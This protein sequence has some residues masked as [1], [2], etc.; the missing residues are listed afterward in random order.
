MPLPLSEVLDLEQVED[1]VFHGHSDPVRPMRVFGGQVASQALVAAGRTVPPGRPVHSLHA[2]FLRPGDP[3]VPLTYEVDPIRDGRTFST[4]RVT[5]HQGDE[6]IFHLSASFQVPEDGIEHQVH[7]VSPV[8]PDDLPSTE[9]LLAHSPAGKAWWD[10]VKGFFPLDIRFVAEPVRA[11]VLRGERPEPRQQIYVR[12]RNTLSDDPLEH[13]CALTYC[14][15][16]FLLSTALPPHG[17]VMGGPGDVQGS[18]LDHAMWFHAPFRADEWLLYDMEGS[19]AGGGRA[20]CR[21]R[22]FDSTGQLVATVM[23]EGLLRRPRT[24]TP[25]ASPVPEKE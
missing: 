19:W 9:E 13:V 2:Y 8:H 25:A 17:L 15:D 12:A 4:R 22:L 1:L 20:L 5:A 3:T 11:Q 10:V 23:Q 14:S 18:S 6:P 16:I 21:G 24:R 7:Q